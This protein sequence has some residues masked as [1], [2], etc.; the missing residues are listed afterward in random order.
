MSLV[1]TNDLAQKF[2]WKGM[3]GKRSFLTVRINKVVISKY[4][5]CQWCNVA[6]AFVNI[7]CLL[8]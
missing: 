8:L 1:M 6:L 7:Y 5:Y 3:G 4:M 2:N